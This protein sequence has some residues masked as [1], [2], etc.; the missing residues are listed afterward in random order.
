MSR[1]RLFAALG[2]APL[3]AALS[4]SPTAAA[5]V[6]STP[7][8]VTAPEA[9]PPCRNLV[10]PPKTPY[11]RGCKDGF[12]EGAAA[13]RK[14]GSPP[15]CQRLPAPLKPPK[16]DEYVRGRV[17]GYKNGYNS[18][19][20]ETYKKNCVKQPDAPVPPPKQTQDDV[21]RNAY[22][23][24]KVTGSVWGRDDAMKNCTRTNADA[25]LPGRTDVIAIGWNNGYRDGY[26]TAYDEAYGKHCLN[27]QTS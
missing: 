8:E 18:T 22:T 2:A 24:G 16:Q 7:E 14:H 10:I 3:L 6:V 13:G 23:N 20:D 4:V 26:N 25:T 5:Q 21:Y 1:N 11:Y 19:Y 12:I 15:V 27:K 17:E 9:A